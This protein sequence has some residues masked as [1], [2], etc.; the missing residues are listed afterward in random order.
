MK[1]W[2]LRRKIVVSVGIIILGVMGV[3][4]FFHIQYV[5][6]EYFQAVEWRSEILVQNLKKEITQ[7][8]TFVRDW[9][10]E[11]IVPIPSLEII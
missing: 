3:T 7:Q 9:G 11:F 5:Q 4:T 10:A 6:D 2:S 8:L 1:N